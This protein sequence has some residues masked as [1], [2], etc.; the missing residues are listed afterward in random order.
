MATPGTQEKTV[1]LSFKTLRSDLDASRRAIADLNKD[2]KALDLQ[3]NRVSSTYVSVGNNLK[4]AS[5]Q[6]LSARNETLKGTQAIKEQTTALDRYNQALAAQ[7][8]AGG[9]GGTGGANPTGTIGRGLKL[10]GN[11]LGQAGIDTGLGDLGQIAQQVTPLIEGVGASMGQVALAAPLAGVAL[12]A[13]SIAAKKFAEDME[14]N[15]QRITNAIDTQKTYY[16]LLQTGTSD[17][18]KLGL[19]ELRVKLAVA[20][21]VRRD[22]QAGQDQLKQFGILQGLAEQFTGLTDQAKA[23]DQEINQ[24]RGQIDALTRALDSNQVAANDAKKA[25]EDYAGVLEEQGPNLAQQIQALRSKEAQTL[26]QIERQREQANEQIANIEQRAADQRVAIAEREAQA[27]AQALLNLQRANAE[28]SIKLSQQDADTK[29]N[30]QR[31][32]TA[33]ARDHARRMLQIRRDELNEETDLIAARDF[34]GLAQARRNLNQ[35][36]DEE[37]DNF[38]A[39]RQERLTQLKQQLQDNRTAFV[40]ERE[41]RQ[42]A[43]QQQLA[44]LRA[45]QKRDL[46]ATTAASNIEI[47]R[48]Q[49]KLKAQITMENSAYQIML[50]QEAEFLRIR[51]QLLAGAISAEQAKAA[52]S[53]NTGSSGGSTPIDATQPHEQK[54][55]GTGG[56]AGGGYMRAG[57]KGEVNEAGRE[58]FTTGGRTFWLPDVRGYFTPTRGGT[59][60]P[61]SGGGNMP[62]ISITINGTN[63]QA[64]LREVNTRLDKALGEIV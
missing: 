44:D 34:A 37:S 14:A 28:A 55:P 6:A 58:S 8:S 52:A 42:R 17:S 43:Y 29:L 51:Q 27:E 9:G 60:N 41:A 61:A 38:S 59:V 35:K 30:Y 23:A 3:G 20:E 12:V 54:H 2:L 5:A 64:I 57:Q 62:P 36:L 26:E 21:A 24:T 1:S 32:E 45:A 46:A 19:E 22:I 39:A 50:K 11:V 18:I 49:E 63:K 47:S 53:R 13:L 33:A 40:R 16:E 15:R 10:A 4:K 56:F 7:K 31:Q 25:A 48:L